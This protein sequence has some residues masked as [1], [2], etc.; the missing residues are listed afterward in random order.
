MVLI[1]FQHLST[2]WFKTYVTLFG[3]TSD[4]RSVA[5]HVKVF[6]HI[7]VDHIPSNFLENFAR[8]TATRRAARSPNYNV[9]YAVDDLEDSG[10]VIEKLSGQNIVSYDE[11]VEHTFKRIIL[12][13]A[14]AYWDMRRMLREPVQV[15]VSQ[16]DEDGEEACAKLGKWL[17]GQWSAQ[18]S[19][20]QPP[21]C[22]CFNDQIGI[23]LQFMIDNDFMA[24]D[25]LCATGLCR[26][27]NERMTT[28]DVDIICDDL[29]KVT[30]IHVDFKRLSYDLECNLRTVNG[31][32]VFPVSSV[33]PIITIGVS[34]SHDGK[35]VFCL[36]E[37]P[38]IPGIAVNSFTTETEMLHAYNEFVT[39]Y[40]PD[41][42]LG[43]NINR[44][45]NVYYR[46]RCKLLGVKFKWSRRIGFLCTIREIVTQ[47]NQRGTQEVL[48][49]EIPG[50]VILDSYEKFRA[51]HN[52]RSY[53]LD[54]LGEHF[55]Q[56][57]KIALPYSQ[58]PIKFTTADGRAELADYCVQDSHLVLELVRTQYK[59]V[60]TIQMSNV[61]GISPNDI[62]QRG[63]GIR[64]IGLMLRYA[65]KNRPR[66]FIPHGEVAEESFKG[67]VVL[68]PLRG[69]YDDAVICV[70]FAS[71]YPSIMQAMN[72][73]YETLVSPHTIST[74]GWTEGEDVR[75]VP[76]YEMGQRLRIIHNP[77]NCSFVTTKVREGILPKMLREILSERAIVKGQMKAHWGTPLY[78][79]LNGKQLAL[80]VTA[81]SIYGFTGAKNG[82]L[83][84]LRI[85]SSV[86][87]YGRGLTLRTMDMV[88]N[89][90]AWMG[91]KV[92]YGDSVTGNTP[93]LVRIEGM[94]QIRSIA[95][96]GQTWNCHRGEKE[97]CELDIEVWSD[98]G[99]TRAVRVIRHKTQT[100][101][102]RV[103]TSKGAVDVTQDHSL[104]RP[105]GTET[106][107]RAVRIGQPLLHHRLPL[108][109][110]CPVPWSYKQ[111]Y[112]MGIFMYGEAL[113]GV[114]TSLFYSNGVDGD[115][116]VPRMM[117][118]A[119]LE[120]L[121]GFFE[122]VLDRSPEH[123]RIAMSLQALMGIH[124]IARRLGKETSLAHKTN[125]KQLRMRIVE[126]VARD[127]TVK[128]KINLGKTSDYVYD[129]T[130]ANHHFHAGVG[131]MIVHNTDS[132]FIHLS[133]AICDAPDNKQ[134]V[135]KA[136]EVGKV[137]AAEITEQFLKP[138]LMEYES[139]F[140]PPFLLLKK[141]RY[142]GK[143]CLP[144]RKPKVYIKG[145]ECVRRDFAPIVVATQQK[146]IK[147]LLENDVEGATAMIRTTFQ[148]LF[149]GE[150]PV[151]DLILSKKL[152]QLPQHYKSK[153]P[154]VELAKRLK[155]ERPDKAPV[156][157]DRVEY[158]IRAGM[159]DLNQR[160]ITPDEV[161]NFVI[162]YNYYADKQLRKPLDRIMDLVC[163][164]NQLFEKHAV[165]APLNDAGIVKYLQ[166]KPKRK[167]KR[168]T[169]QTNKKQCL[170]TTE[171]ADIRKF[172]GI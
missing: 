154:H 155:R 102:V 59:I 6:P 135:E 132:C 116:I 107:P 19:T 75:T 152:S 46:D 141:K 58:I 134:L 100:S 48:R 128:K 143:L 131:C 4:G 28:C 77:A 65:K 92:I 164:V 39:T 25:T 94:L 63:Q 124:Y 56:Q 76:D 96:L 149:A 69:K 84:E 71:L 44:F 52:L 33:D 64:T 15:I 78:D 3:R 14:Y 137:M 37:T 108:V 42:I 36:G 60:N 165:S 55:L 31:K 29:K 45:D 21:D 159:E 26:E 140:E 93:V 72:M 148:Q 68:P 22:T 168:H 150:I 43:H 18:Y 130:T 122:G 40:D 87:K 32:L 79:V 70:D 41:F 112:R 113:P 172:L 24:C 91:S 126:D 147:L 111:A 120:I 62:L 30:P 98:L 47:S 81:N 73:S 125:S 2:E 9:S 127:Y 83:P 86:T 156:A 158:L 35:H 66:L 38:A 104:L 139:A 11:E 97:S 133:R 166:R 153:M 162:D 49:L 144:G 50:R 151:K 34:T 17:K 110:A 106:S 89:N 16:V 88:D 121:W 13:T 129:L 136:H 99:W 7:V 160:A 85:A 27:R 109:T 123:N 20:L 115:K 101:I 57:R 51:D 95:E 119:P 170:K 169:P 146:M 142:I 8:Y 5:A 61:T 171:Y 90:P 118:H 23:G 82:F 167:P 114:D 145:C 53:K 161:D 74:M 157:G 103:V 67:A 105:D 10:I 117:L 80:K 1:T 138:V 163:D 12:P 54:V